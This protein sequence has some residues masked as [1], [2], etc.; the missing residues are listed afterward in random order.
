MTTDPTEKTNQ[1]NQS[2]PDEFKAF[3]RF[4][5]IKID[6]KQK[7]NSLMKGV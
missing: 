6:A 7:V 4:N 1:N 2:I 5:E 3:L